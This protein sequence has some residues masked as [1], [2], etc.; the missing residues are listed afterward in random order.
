MNKQIMR[1]AVCGVLLLAM[2]IA[3]AIPQL[4]LDVGGGT[5][6]QTGSETAPPTPETIVAQGDVF[7]L[8]A[9]GY[10]NGDINN[11]D[12][13]I[14][15]WLTRQFFVSMAVIPQTANISED[16]GFFSVN[17]ITINTSSSGLQ[18]GVPPVENY[19]GTSDQDLPSH[20]IFPTSFIEL[21]FNFL[22]SNKANPYNT[23]ENAGA[24]PTPAQ[25]DS[26]MYFQAFDIDIGGLKEGYAIHFDLYATL[27][28]EVCK[29][30]G[31]GRDKIRIC[32]TDTQILAK[33][34]FSHDAESGIGNGFEPSLAPIPEPDVLWLLGGG[35]IL[36]RSFSKKNGSNPFSGCGKKPA[37]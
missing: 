4:Q 10:P 36:L 9:Y 32:N 8:Y 7:T 31:T 5:Y 15:D 19:T 30:E 23:A 13:G 18:F 22:D 25:N 3:V 11:N 14:N 21:G 37:Q 28:E 17:G 27:G 26:F 34:P 33:A 12:T 1:A 2:D 24:G 6:N 35:L 20:G 16:F 29:S